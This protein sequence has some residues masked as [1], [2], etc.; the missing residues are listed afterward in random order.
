MICR[1]G[2]SLVV[3]R[4]GNVEGDSWKSR[5]RDAVPERPAVELLRPARVGHAQVLAMFRRPLEREILAMLAR[6]PAGQNVGHTL[7][8]KY[9]ADD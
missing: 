4:V 3:Q 9:V 7:A 8:D 5:L 1:H 6:L 2:G